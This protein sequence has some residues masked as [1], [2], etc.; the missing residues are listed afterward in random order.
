MK[1]EVLAVQAFLQV[2]FWQHMSRKSRKMSHVPKLGFFGRMAPH[3]PKRNA[4]N[5]LLVVRSD[6]LQP[7]Y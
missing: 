4:V 6:G 7:S 2:L 1:G 3:V 5:L